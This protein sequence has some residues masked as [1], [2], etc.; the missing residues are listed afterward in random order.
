MLYFSDQVSTRLHRVRKTLGY[1]L[2]LDLAAHASA[3]DRGRCDL[4]WIGLLSA[5]NINLSESLGYVAGLVNFVRVDSW[6]IVRL[7]G[8]DELLTWTVFFTA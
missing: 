3:L 6:Q 1:Q 5:L 7:G 2:L 8:F 4:R